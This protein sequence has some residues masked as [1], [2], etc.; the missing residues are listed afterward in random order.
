MLTRRLVVG[1]RI[2]RRP[3]ASGS[4]CGRGWTQLRR[5]SR[6]RWCRRHPELCTSSRVMA[7]AQLAVPAAGR[8]AALLGCDS[9]AAH[10]SQSAAGPC[11]GPVDGQG[12][13]SADVLNQFAARSSGREGGAARPGAQQGSEQLADGRF[14]DAAAPHASAPVQSPHRSASSRRGL[15]HHCLGAALR[16]QGTLTSKRWCRYCGSRAVAWQQ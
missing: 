2:L 4:A 14:Q 12:H 16:H 1:R 6:P 5:R 9:A 8:R 7:D 3:S 15:L 11:S 13:P 10:P